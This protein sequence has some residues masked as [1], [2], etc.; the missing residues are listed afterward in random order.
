MAATIPDGDFLVQQIDE[1]SGT[2][3]ADIDLSNAF[4][5]IPISRKYQQ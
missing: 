4:F 3:H 2:S 5:S 1:A